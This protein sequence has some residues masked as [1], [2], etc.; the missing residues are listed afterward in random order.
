[1]SYL[2]FEKMDKHYI[3]M[4]KSNDGFELWLY[5][6]KKDQV[7]YNHFQD[8]NSEMEA[9][10]YFCRELRILIDIFDSTN[11]VTVDFPSR[12]YLI[13]IKFQR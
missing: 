9:I 1:M 2:L 8:K 7:N 11:E 3:V 12:L 5:E 13:I 4:I 10:Y 6:T